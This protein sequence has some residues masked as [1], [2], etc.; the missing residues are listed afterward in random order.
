MNSG[1]PIKPSEVPA[2]KAVVIPPFVF[3]CFNKCIALHFANGRARFTLG[4]VVKMV[5]EECDKHHIE[6]NSKWMDVEDSYR[7]QG[8]KVEYD[9]PAYCES[10]PATFTFIQIK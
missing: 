4:E 6:Y 9:S 1:V 10:Y 5:E 7:A 8:W 3:N 2:A